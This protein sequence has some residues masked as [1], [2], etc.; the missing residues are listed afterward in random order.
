MASR[1]RPLRGVLLRSAPAGGFHLLDAGTHAPIATL[2]DLRAVA[3]YCAANRMKVVTTPSASP[4]GATQAADTAAAP[5]AADT[6]PKP[7]CPTVRALREG[8]TT[9]P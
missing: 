4:Q 7:P 3:D 5:G 1:P 8:G 2:R 6:A 9:C